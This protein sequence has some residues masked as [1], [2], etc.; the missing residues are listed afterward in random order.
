MDRRVLAGVLAAA[1]LIATGGCASS[2]VSTIRYANVPDFPPTTPASV[3]ILRSEPARPHQMLAELSMAAPTESTAP[4]VQQVEEKLRAAAAALGADA[5]V[6]VVD[7]LQPTAVASRTWWGS[8]AR[9]TGGR[10]VIAVAIK[11]R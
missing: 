10:D 4:A 3:Q 7:P 11:Y 1:A 8:S 5:V 6:L 2:N 9:G